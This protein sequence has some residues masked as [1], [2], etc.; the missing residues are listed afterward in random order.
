MKKFKVVVK[1]AP[2]QMKY[3]G[4]SSY[5]LSLNHRGIYSNMADNP[6]DDI[7]KTIKP[8]PR[9]EANI[10]AEKGETAWGDFNGDGHKEH[11]VIPGKL[12]SEGGTPLNVPEGTF[13]YSNTRKMKLGGPILSHFGKSKNDKKKYTPAELAKQYDVNKYKAILDDPNSDA[14]TKKTAKNM[15]ANYEKKLA[16]LALVQEGKKGF[17]QGIPKVAESLINQQSEKGGQQPTAEY[18]GMYAQGG[19]IPTYDMSNP[20]MYQDGGSPLYSTQGQVLRNYTN[21]LAYT[22]NEWMPNHITLP[23]VYSYAKGG[24]KKSKGGNQKLI[25]GVAQML[26][27]GAQ[28]EEVLQELIK[29]RIPEKKAIAII[30]GVMEQLGA[31]QQQEQPQGI[32]PQQAV[33]QQMSPEEQQ[34]MMMAQQQGMEQP[35]MVYG[36]DFKYGGMHGNPGTYAD[37]YS[38]TYSNGT[39]FNQGG[40]YVPDYGMA[41]GGVYAAGGQSNQETLLIKVAELIQQ[42]MAPEEVYQQL[43]QANIPE[44]KAQEII[45]FVIEQLQ[46]GQEQMMQGPEGQQAPS[47]EMMQGQPPMGMYGGGYA[48]GGSYI[49]NMADSAY[50][51]P[52][53]MYGMGMEYG[54]DYLPYAKLGLE[55]SEEATDD[56]KKPQKVKKSEISDYEKKGFKRIGNTNVWRRGTERVE[57]VPPTIIKGTP[58]VKGTPGSSPTVGQ[59]R[60]GGKAGK[61]WENWIKAQLAKGVTIDE[62]VKKGHGTKEGLGKYS[63][64]YKPAT[65]GTAEVKGTEDKKECKEG[66]KLNEVTGNCERIIPGEEFITYEE[67]GPKPGTPSPGTLPGKRSKPRWTKPDR[68]AALAAAAFPPKFYGPYEGDATARIPIPTFYDPS[69]A[70]AENSGLAKTMMAGYQGPVQG[71][72]TNAMAVQMGAAEKAANILSDYQNKNVGVANQFGPMQTQ[73]ANALSEWKANRKTRLSDKTVTGLQNLDNANRAYVNAVTK[74]AVPAEYRG[75]KFNALNQVSPFNFNVQTGEMRMRPGMDAYGTITG[76]QGTGT[77]TGT[78]DQYVAE[79]AKLKGL[80]LDPKTIHYLM[81]QKFPGYGASTSSRGGSNKAALAEYMSLMGGSNSAYPANMGGYDMGDLYDG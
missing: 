73:I 76:G 51:L 77:S 3:G 56:D 23:D 40:S 18:G 22:P 45:Q 39:Y 50:G 69:R 31:S 43:I 19:F 72:T 59:A 74:I 53:F 47:Q 64:Y 26:Q 35:Q 75:W 66:Y 71:Y 70:L 34:M 41:Y 28:P 61:A 52:Q 13:I 11:M 48:N 7:G 21:T 79:A 20:Y 44:N 15:I 2:E 80:Q 12:H 60:G 62:L 68:W 32:M 16:E 81:Q 54:G 4:Q 57:T 6:H 65:T 78:Y 30:Q 8:V 46:G 14:L 25:Q 63:P 49:P 42:G 37:G 5:G 17:P 10:E 58:G 67:E 36:G 29:L 9:N 1:K 33:P 38:G 24:Q 55:T 27:Q